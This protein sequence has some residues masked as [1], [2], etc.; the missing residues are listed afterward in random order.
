[1][2]TRKANILFILLSLTPLYSDGPRAAD[3]PRPFEAS[4]TLIKAGLSIGER[5]VSLKAEA[6]AQFLYQAESWPVGVLSLFKS[7]RIVERSH[8]TL[9][10]DDI[11]PLSYS[12]RQSG[13]RKRDVSLEFDWDKLEV[14]N[15]IDTKPW[16]MDIP[17]GAMDKLVYTLALMRDMKQGRKEL[18]YAIADGGR[19]KSYRFEQLGEEQVETP[20]GVFKAAHL[21]RIRKPGKKR[22]THVWL[23]AELDYLPVVIEQDEKGATYRMVLSKWSPQP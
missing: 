13:R 1:M 21:K 5:Q 8:W 17:V 10:G 23:A 11:R 3:T 9:A 18:V 4:Y 19:L 6:G 20:L 22:S 15:T 14:T 12:Y 16:R 7:D 2:S